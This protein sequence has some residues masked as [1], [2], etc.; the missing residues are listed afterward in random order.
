MRLHLIRHGETTSNAEGRVQGHLDV[1]LSDRGLRQAA[2]LA[3]RL[4]GLPIAALYGSTLQRAL[5]T[6]QIV[7]ERIE[8]DLQ[9]RDFLM[10][11]DVGE[12]SGLTGEEIGEKFPAWRKHRYLTNAQDIVPGYEGD[13][14]FNK[15][16]VPN[17]RALIEAHSDQ[18]I[19]V[20][21][22]GGVIGAF[23]RHVL[24]I[25]KRRSANIDNAS[26]AT[27]NIRD[28]S[29]DIQLITLNDT[30]HLD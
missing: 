14:A 7:A 28:A 13:E 19:A 24:G 1:P 2:L 4:A 26:L 18:E 29:S 12:L 20:V 9:E 22:H 5:R 15:R 30:C 8:V 17:M 25:T 10:E 3:E 23:C 16:V 27:F 21:T 6:A 11:R